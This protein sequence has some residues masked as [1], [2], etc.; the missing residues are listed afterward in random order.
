[1]TI[2]VDFCLCFIWQDNNAVITITKAYSLRR[3]EDRVLVNRH[4]PKATSTN[5]DIVWPVFE[6]YHEKMLKI[7]VPINDYNHH[8]NSVD[9]SSYLRDKFTCLRHRESRNWRPIL[10]LGRRLR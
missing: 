3:E 4:R 2:I 8:M 6:G 1:V 10:Y 5:A 9:I 7:P